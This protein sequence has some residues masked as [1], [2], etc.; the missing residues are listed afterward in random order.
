MVVEGERGGEGKGGRGLGL[1]LQG[2]AYDKFYNSLKTKA[3]RNLYPVALRKLMAFQ[4]VENV[5][6]LL[7]S[8]PEK[9]A[10]I[11]SKVIDW[12]VHMKDVEQMAPRSVTTYLAGVL[13]FYKKNM[14]Y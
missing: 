13:K 9:T 7:P 6:D 8:L 14:S 1:V 3:T 4:K 2:N 12:V 10:L 11:N 5:N